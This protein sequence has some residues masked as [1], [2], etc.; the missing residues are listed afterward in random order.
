MTNPR[1]SWQR[2]ECPAWCAVDH[3]EDDHPDD[4]SHRTDTP[5]VPVIARARR[6]DDGLVFETG[7]MEFEVGVSRPD[8]EVDTWIYVGAGPGQQLEVSRESAKRL[9]RALDAQLRATRDGDSH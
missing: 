5:A 3:R 2:D 6:F 7:A 4:R 1:P 9:L 8:G